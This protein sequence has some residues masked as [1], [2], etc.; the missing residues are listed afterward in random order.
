MAREK[1]VEKGESRDK[2]TKKAGVPKSKSRTHDLELEVQKKLKILKDDFE[3]E[4]KSRELADLIARFKT[5]VKS[6]SEIADKL[7]TYR[8]TMDGSN[9]S[10]V[11]VDYRENLCEIL[12]CG[13]CEGDF[14]ERSYLQMPVSFSGG[15]F[16]RTPIANILVDPGNGTITGL[17]ELG[18]NFYQRKETSKKEKH[19]DSKKDKVD[20]RTVFQRI[21]IVVASHYHPSARLDLHT[22]FN[23]LGGYCP[24]RA[25]ESSD[26]RAE[27]VYLFSTRA[28]I[29]ERNDHLSVL[30]PSDKRVIKETF[31]T[32]PE[33]CWRISGK[34]GAVKI[35]AL[36][37]AE[38]QVTEPESRYEMI[39][40]TFPAYH[41]EVAKDGC[42][43]DEDGLGGKEI[44]SFFLQ[45]KD[46]QGIGYG[47]FF[48]GDTEYRQDL[49][50]RLGNLLKGKVSVLIA[51]TK[52]VDYLNELYE[53]NENIPLCPGN[54][55]WPKMRFTY[56]QLGFLGTLQLAKC[57]APKVLVMR[58]FGLE[59][60]VED[61]KGLY[62]YAP[63]KLAIIR[64]S[65]EALLKSSQDCQTEKVIIPGRHKVTIKGENKVVTQK[66]VRGF[67]SSK[68]KTYGTQFQYKTVVPELSRD[69]DTHIQMMVNE[70]RK[71]TQKDRDG[72]P[73]MVIQ[74]ESGGGKT[75]LAKAI[76]NT[77]KVEKEKI[78]TYDLATAA[79]D[80]INFKYE[81]F[82]WLKDSFTGANYENPGLLGVPDGLVVFN[83][84]EKL[85]FGQAIKF[86]DVLEEWK[87]TKFGSNENFKV[88]AKIIFT[89]NIDV[90]EIKEFPEDFK[91]RL[92]HRLL[93][94]PRLSSL[95]KK[96]YE[97]AL[98]IF[99]G[100]WC[101][102]NSVILDKEAWNMVFEVD[103]S[104][105]AFRTLNGLLHKARLLAEREYRIGSD[106][107]NT[108]VYVAG[109][110]VERARIDMLVPFRNPED[111]EWEKLP[112]E[113]A[114]VMAVWLS[115]EC[116]NNKTYTSMK[117]S[118][119]GE[120][121]SVAFKDELG[122][123]LAFFKDE[124]KIWE[125]F[126]ENEDAVRA[127]TQS[128]DIVEYIKRLDE[129]CIK[130]K[131]DR[132]F[133]FKRKRQ[134]LEDRSSGFKWILD[135]NTT[136]YSDIRKRFMNVFQKLK[137]EQD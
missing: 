1:A 102:K 116:V 75:L 6:T 110:F 108:I 55:A 23:M 50:D 63:Q 7:N 56:N 39:L 2:K 24:G 109:E 61:V 54:S 135:K 131:L 28:V 87:Y 101:E 18:V 113:L 97:Q 77:L 88:L 31:V 91:N 70:Q 118:K 40:R 112:P 128:D 105:G 84:L 86:L 9:E 46:D 47:I 27:K 81:V 71:T 26:D 3:K 58:A 104:K 69:I 125:H 114:W 42:G 103:L 85:P 72:K 92:R 115:N 79:S 44:G 60:M 99:T 11:P 98:T 80:P 94:V 73:Y 32:R 82:G 126:L 48:T 64:E 25:K 21:D 34:P 130:C 123:V 107:E 65:M 89:T 10:I 41:S 45:G 127:F 122:R 111:L 15:F 132:Q 30:I 4:E 66:I 51:N 59:C 100:H 129:D 37:V 22:I 68:V 52:T 121:G 35:E 13:M 49:A 5:T 117:G 36:N 38:E 33:K 17:R 76:A 78:V 20:G 62:K 124:G 137:K 133:K 8:E 74:G 134:W 106:D 120:L 19:G 12:F 119:G 93:T 14:S 43:Q 90:E 67:T 136:Q 53:E 96:Q 57:L 29:E 83:Q 95:G 16:I